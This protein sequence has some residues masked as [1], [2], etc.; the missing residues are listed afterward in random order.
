MTK[1]K[2]PQYN[3]Q[4]QGVYIRVPI[5]IWIHFF[6]EFTFQKLKINYWPV[7]SK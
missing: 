2:I 6:N 3:S 5:F 1:I 7:K 4:I